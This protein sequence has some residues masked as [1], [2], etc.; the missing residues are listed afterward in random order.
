MM[1]LAV[2]KTHELRNGVYPPYGR[3]V[4]YSDEEDGNWQ[5]MPVSSTT[6]SE[7]LQKTIQDFG[8]RR[9]D[10]GL[11]VIV[12]WPDDELTPSSIARA[13]IT[14]YFL[15]IVLGHLEIEI[16]HPSE[17]LRVINEHTI[18]NEIG[19]MEERDGEDEESRES[20]RA[21]VKLTKWA[22]DDVELDSHIELEAPVQRT[23]PWSK[24]D[25]EEL[26]TRLRE[27]FANK[28]RLA[29]LLNVDRQTKEGSGFGESQL[30]FSM[31][32]AQKN[33]R[34]AM[35][36]SLGAICRFLASTL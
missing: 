9:E 18:D 27:R 26:L 28:D 25:E 2:L 15:P 17:K 31:L 35:I 33:W 5:P 7:F 30:L 11:S 34:L 22:Y 29:F 10:S 3:F 21:I 1:G 4:A 23:A 13:A 8:L 19:Q 20:M 16:S 24:P 6:S 12:P 14:Q 32:S 36:T